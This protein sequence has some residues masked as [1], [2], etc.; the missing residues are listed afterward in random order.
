[1]ATTKKLDADDF[2]IDKM[3]ESIPDKNTEPTMFVP[4][5]DLTVFAIAALQSLDWNQIG[6]SQD[7]A[8]K[9]CWSMAEAM[10]RNR[11]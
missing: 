3:V 8:A 5:N 7:E 9:L 2:T 10:M 6:M 1:M 11:P 4:A